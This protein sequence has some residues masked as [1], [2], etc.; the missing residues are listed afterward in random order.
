[1]TF[2]SVVEVFKK[3]V[4]M[5]RYCLVPPRPKFYASIKHWEVMSR[6]GICARITSAELQKAQN[7]NGFI[8]IGYMSDLKKCEFWID[9]T[10]NLEKVSKKLQ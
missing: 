9:E 7:N 8:K 1:M 6:Y 3:L 4:R 10:L 2:L 5:N